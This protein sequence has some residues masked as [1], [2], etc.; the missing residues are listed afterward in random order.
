MIGSITGNP[1]A[2]SVVKSAAF[3][4]ASPETRHWRPET[5]MARI[6]PGLAA[7]MCVELWGVRPGQVVF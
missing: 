7:E 3:L 6:I 2:A 1:I 5:A 4:G